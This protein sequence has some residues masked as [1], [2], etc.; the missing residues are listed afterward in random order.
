MKERVRLVDGEFQA[1]IEAGAGERACAED[2]AYG[3]G[4]FHI[5]AVDTVTQWQV[6]GCVE[7]ISEST[8]QLCWQGDGVPRHSVV[9]PAKLP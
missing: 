8:L 1:E 7:T 6:V 3:R 2:V 9:M 4:P 5:N